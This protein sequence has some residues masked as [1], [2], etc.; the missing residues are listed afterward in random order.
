MA[1]YL[2]LPA[3]SHSII[4]ALVEEC[5]AAAW[6]QSWLNP[7]R[8]L[9]ASSESDAGTIAHQ[10]L[11]ENSEAGVAVI[12]PIDHPAEKTGAIPV[13]WTNK[14]I[15]AARD[16]A[17]AS[18][19]T[20]VLAPQMAQIR[21][22]V[23]VAR[24]YLATLKETEPAVYEAFLPGAG[25]S[26]LTLLWEEDGVACRMRPDR[27]ATD[28]RLIMNYKTTATSVE[29]DRWGRSQLIGAGHYIGASWYRRGI[30]A[31]FGVEC[32]YVYLVQS[33]EA[34]YLCSLVGVAPAVF[35]LGEQKCK[36]GLQAWR[37]CVARNFWP[38]YPRRVV[39][40]ELPV[41]EWQRWEDRQVADPTI[42][43]GSQP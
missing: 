11:L 1:E 10:I 7:R 32:D 4:Q 13:G 3:V 8:E 41:W 31:L 29:P 5:P 37:Q 39:Y 25:T 21:A 15:K 38:S 40:P 20:P 27:M 35:E 6:W 12:D 2:A 34:P 28:Y 26:E 17:R 30:R 24:E 16:L 23:D 14:S 9:D 19:Q 43:Y 22:M 33:T 42:A 36:I 18:G